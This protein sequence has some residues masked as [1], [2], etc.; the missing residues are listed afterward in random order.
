MARIHVTLPLVVRRCPVTEVMCI[1]CPYHV[2]EV[3]QLRVLEIRQTYVTTKDLQPLYVTN[4]AF[5][6]DNYASGNRG[7]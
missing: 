6:S 2:V 3:L 4:D 1:V 7:V 5:L